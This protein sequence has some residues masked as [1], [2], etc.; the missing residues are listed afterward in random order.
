MGSVRG[1]AG[2]VTFVAPLH[3]MPTSEAKPALSEVEGR[4][5]FYLAAKSRFLADGSGSE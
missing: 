4:N 2:I 5:C 3:V 1:D